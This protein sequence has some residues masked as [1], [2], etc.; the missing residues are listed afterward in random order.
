MGANT[1]NQFFGNCQAM[2]FQNVIDINKVVRCAEGLEGKDTN[3]A[4]PSD[5]LLFNFPPNSKYNG[6]DIRG[7]FQ[8][9]FISNYSKLLT[10][11]PVDMNNFFNPVDINSVKKNIDALLYEYYVYM[12]KVRQITEK[13]VNP[14]FIKVLGGAQNASYENMRNFILTHA[15][16]SILLQTEINLGTLLGI[17]V[18]ADQLKINFVDNFI[19]MVHNLRGRK[20]L[21][22]IGGSSLVNNPIYFPYGIVGSMYAN[23]LLNIIEQVQYS[24]IL[25]ERIFITANSYALRT[26][27]Q[28]YNIP[29]GES[30]TF[31]NFLSVFRKIIKNGSDQNVADIKIYV[32][33]L[34]FQIV[35]AC[36]SLH[37]SG[38]N[39]NDLHAGNILIKKIT[40]CI[41]E[42]HIDNMKYSIFTEFTS[43]LYDFDRSTS[44]DYNNEIHYGKKNEVLRNTLHPLKDIIKIFW[45]LYRPDIKDI[46]NMYENI[47]ITTIR[48]EILNILAKPGKQP[49]IKIFFNKLKNQFVE[50]EI[51]QDD[52]N[53][54]FV[55]PRVIL[56]R[57]Y[58][59]FSSEND[60]NIRTNPNTNKYTYICHKDLF[61][62][63]GELVSQT[64]I[65]F[66]AKELENECKNK[67]DKLQKANDEIL[68][69][70]VD[71]T[72]K[73]VDLLVDELEELREYKLKKEE[74]NKYENVGGKRRRI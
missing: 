58:N 19:H 74:E 54:L 70:L 73:T 51:T 65:N 29:E 6:E 11:F 55:E 20:S 61:T 4:S 13:N 36:Y 12:E 46:K 47:R 62:N 32:F 1:S 10:D 56:E 31:D 40:P 33:L 14:H 69:K 64:Q 21:T 66:F 43:M 3:S 49:G 48:G 25:T 16:N 44:I 2:N 23:I 17:N 28:F 39:N 18:I 71:D 26:F 38:V 8:K 9:I 52:L 53:T 30:I 59:K 15:N 67:L 68:N 50:T 60:E 35:S 63:K 42:Y 22:K 72:N 24:F 57:L 37:L 34:F 45:Y 7:G 5:L 41:N 27:E